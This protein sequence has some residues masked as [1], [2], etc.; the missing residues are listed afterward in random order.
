MPHEASCASGD[1]WRVTPLGGQ[2]SAAEENSQWRAPDNLVVGQFVVSPGAD[3][4][5]VA[6]LVEA[7]PC[8]V[9]AVMFDADLEPGRHTLRLRVSAEKDERSLGHAMRA[10][11]FVAN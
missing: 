7:T 3:T 10:L 5:R 11:H 6:N 2:R 9:L 8:H 1:V 4:K